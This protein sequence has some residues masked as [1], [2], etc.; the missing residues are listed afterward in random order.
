MIVENL[1]VCLGSGE[2]Q[3]KRR[4]GKG[5]WKVESGRRQGEGE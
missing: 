5:E 1:R 2:I 4:K 3:S